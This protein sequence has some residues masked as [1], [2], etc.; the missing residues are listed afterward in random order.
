MQSGGGGGVGWGESGAIKFE[1]VFPPSL[2][3]KTGSVSQTFK[4]TGF[5]LWFW[6]TLETLVLEMISGDGWC[7]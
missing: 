1:A 7:C 3:N 5:F 4:Q 6:F 2:S